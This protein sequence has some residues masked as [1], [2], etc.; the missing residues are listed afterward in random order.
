MIGY[1]WAMVEYGWT[2]VYDGWILLDPDLPWLGMVWL[3]KIGRFFPVLQ[4][5]CTKVERNL[6]TLSF[7]EENI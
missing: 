6:K 3:D 4:P 5:N 7:F 2:L 1:G